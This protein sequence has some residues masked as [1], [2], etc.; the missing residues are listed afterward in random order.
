MTPIQRFWNLL[1]PFKK[2]VYQI[3]LY[4]ILNGLVNLSLPL[5]IQAIV[6]II[7]MGA[8]TTSWAVLVLFVLIGII[9]SGVFQLTQLRIVENIQQE[10]FAKSSFEFAFRFPQIK[11]SHLQNLHTPELANRFFDTLTIQKNL[12][13]ILVD[14]S[15]AV[16]QAFF[17]L[18]LLSVYS[19]YFLILGVFL[20]TSIW[21]LFKTTSPKGMS[22]SILESKFKYIVAHWLEE[23]ARTHKS[24]KKF[25]SFALHLKK[26]DKKTIEYLE[27]REKH[28]GV[29]VTQFKFFILFKV[30][31]AAGL[32]ILGGLLVYNEQM[33]IGQF[34]AA[35]IIILLILTSTEKLINSID[36]IY[37]L[38]TA[39]DKIGYITDLELDDKKKV[40]LKDTNLGISVDINSLSYPGNE[41]GD[42]YFN[43]FSTN[44]KS[45][46]KTAVLGENKVLK[47][48]LLNIISGFID[49]RTGAVKLDGIPVE[50]L[51]KSIL[52]KQ[53]S[54]HF[55]TNELFEASLLDNITVGRKISEEK[56]REIISL[57]GLDLFVS[58]LPNG[59]DSII[60]PSNYFLPKDVTQK[61][62]L[63]RSLVTKCRLYLFEYPF[64]YIK[65]YDK[66]RII[67]YMVEEFKESTFIVITE[68]EYWLNIA[69]QQVIISKGGGNA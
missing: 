38:L 27:A 45:G 20:V 61:I 28:F 42:N 7:Q 34:V 58:N 13:K 49:I 56:I 48:I 12:P 63:A 15:L 23:V 17:G 46:S 6:N 3:Y 10:I 53:I 64:L 22:T 54:I 47:S 67:D 41:N 32:L 35:E 37:D 62:L 36:S 4:A 31:L 16:F 59:L 18:V 8:L 14:F 11:L 65:E 66:E 33:N 25:S 21:V 39:L 60:N 55:S 51:N 29:L 43:N 1:S 44:I 19:P 68:D 40:E 2:E 52:N 9:F 30:L 5:G 57:M 24:F 50:N 69:D 26:T